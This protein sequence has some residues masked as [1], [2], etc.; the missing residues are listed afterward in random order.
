MRDAQIGHLD[1]GV[2]SLMLNYGFWIIVRAT[3][4]VAPNKTIH[5]KQEFAQ[6][7]CVG[8]D[9]ISALS[10][11]RAKMDFAPTPYAPEIWINRF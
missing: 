7:F 4:A 2:G 11:V 8:A 1:V 6:F 3:L 5:T 10:S 9:S